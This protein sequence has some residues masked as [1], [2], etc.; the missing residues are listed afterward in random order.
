M[1]N[2]MNRRELLMKS[3]LAAAATYPISAKAKEESHSHHVQSVVRH[4]DRLHL[5]FSL[6]APVVNARTLGCASRRCRSC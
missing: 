2:A 4:G 3:A 6:K 5:V 1:G